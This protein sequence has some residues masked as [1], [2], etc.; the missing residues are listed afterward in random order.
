[1]ASTLLVHSRS[2]SRDSCETAAFERTPPPASDPLHARGRLRGGTAFAYFDTS[3]LHISS[4]AP[5]SGPLDGG[6]VLTLTG[7]GFND[8]GARV[9]FLGAHATTLSPHALV[10]N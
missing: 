5:S 10:S 7:E 2:R 4:V 8:L 1:M 6:T 3:A 9:A